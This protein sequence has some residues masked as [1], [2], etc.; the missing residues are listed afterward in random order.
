MISKE[1]AVAK[2]RVDQE[3]KKKNPK[4]ENPSTSSP[5]WGQQTS[6]SPPQWR[7]APKDQQAGGAKARQGQWEAGAAGGPLAPLGTWAP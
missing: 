7:S 6:G 5:A 3:H 1:G 4:S 2:A